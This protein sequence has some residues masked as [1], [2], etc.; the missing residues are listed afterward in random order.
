V[1]GPATASRKGQAF[2]A[3]FAVDNYTHGAPMRFLL[4][5]G[6]RMLLWPRPATLHS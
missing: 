2:P 6:F 1:A 4:P 5:L 3:V